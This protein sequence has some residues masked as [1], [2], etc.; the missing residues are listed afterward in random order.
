VPSS[1]TD[2]NPTIGRSLGADRDAVI[3]RAVWQSSEDW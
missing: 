2:K 1:T 3:Y